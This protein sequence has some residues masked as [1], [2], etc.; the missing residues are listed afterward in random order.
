MQSL[1][2]SDE[3]RLLDGVK[4]AVDLVD[5]QGLTPNAAL[6]KIAEQLHY[7]PGFLKAACNA[8]NTGRQLAQWNSSESVLDK[9]ASF[10][11]A[12]YDTVH[13]AMWGKSQEKAAGDLT[14]SLTLP[15]YEDVT[16]QELLDYDLSGF[17][18]TAAEL[19]PHVVDEQ[20]GQ[21]V[22]RAFDAFDYRRRMREEAR[23]QKQA[24]EDRLNLRVHL[25]ED[26]F[27][28]FAYDRLPLAQV[29]HAAA[30]R[31]GESGKQLMA[32]VAA[33]FPKE[34]RA[35]DHR[36]TWGGFHEAANYARE[37][38]TMIEA[39]I[40]HAKELN[41]ARVLFKE[42]EDNLA[43]ARDVYESFIQPLHR[44]LNGNHAK[45]TSSLMGDAG[46]KQAAGVAAGAA[47]GA[48][49]LQLVNR[50]ADYAGK[51]YDKAL[52]KQ[53]DEL[54]SPEHLNEL[55]K[56]RAQVALTQLMSDPDS[57]ISSYDP[58]E[59][60][61]TYN[62]MV[63]LSPRLADQPAA[64]GPLLNKRLVGNT[65]P[66]EVGDMLKLEQTLRHTQEMPATR[67]SLGNQGSLTQNE[68]SI[69]R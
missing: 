53:I 43:A 69:I 64:I 10:P 50:I 17:T 25:L 59:V 48:G 56:I 51:S 18:K 30:V 58:E 28:K 14:L 23:R 6:Q 67:G 1:S 12:D 33:S 57:P 11:L 26:Y 27:R 66:F 29:E 40:K 31:F 5:N 52:E 2:K 42:A 65:E 3:Q 62:D 19:E 32:Y 54:D 24:A 7:S 63:Q 35:S 49:G 68:N 55:R 21:R 45:L 37:P 36:T 61:S 22:K 46:E 20:G 8:F 60:L 15:S 4:L 9:L 39:A 34:K 44:P 13:A 38:Y 41:H 16:R 47:A